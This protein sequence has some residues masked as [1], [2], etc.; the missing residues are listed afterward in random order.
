MVWEW[1]TYVHR[2][3]CVTPSMD[4]LA[5][6]CMQLGRP[7][8]L[9]QYCRP[10][11]LGRSLC[12]PLKAMLTFLLVFSCLP[13]AALWSAVC[14]AA[15]ETLP[16]GVAAWPQSCSTT[17]E[18]NSCQF[19][20]DAGYTGSISG[21]CNADGTYTVSGECHPGENCAVALLR[22]CSFKCKQC[23]AVGS[24]RPSWRSVLMV[25]CLRAS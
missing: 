9:Q 10:V 22:G 20:C 17:T 12:L 19:A 8:S 5:P 4:V 13:A 14:S 3:R 7:Q 11:R 18:G 6:F 23:A 2:A 15:P 21:L 24:T 1:F 25:L 16:T